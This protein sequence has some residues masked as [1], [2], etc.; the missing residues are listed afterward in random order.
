MRK[1]AERKDKEKKMVEEKRKKDY[2][3]PTVIPIDTAFAQIEPMGKSY[4]YAS[5]SK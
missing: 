4:C 2:V 3:R 1:K 5:A